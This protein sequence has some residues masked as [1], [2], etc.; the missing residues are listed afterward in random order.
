MNTANLQLEGIYTVLAALI[1]AL[2]KKEI[3]SSEDLLAALDEAER[4]IETD[5]RRSGDISHA[6]LEAIRFPVRYMKAVVG[7][8]RDG[9]PLPAFGEVATSIGRRKPD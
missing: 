2:E 9:A 1:Q 8:G 5:G 4:T 6:N 7:R 3:L